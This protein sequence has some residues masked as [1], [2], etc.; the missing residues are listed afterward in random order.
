[1]SNETKKFVHFGCWNNRMFT[2]NK[3]NENFQNPISKVLNNLLAN[4][5]K[6]DFFVVAGDNYYP[7]KER[8]QW[9][10]NKNKKSI[11]VKKT[12]FYN[13]AALKAGFTALKKLGKDVFLLLGNH[14]IEPVESLV[15]I[16]KQGK[17]ILNK[18]NIIKKKR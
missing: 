7:T 16:N 14:E 4:K 9:Y 6:Y 3:M 8:R 1:M 5:D 12:K 15:S 18:N 2:E 11:K 10:K 17:M 13:E